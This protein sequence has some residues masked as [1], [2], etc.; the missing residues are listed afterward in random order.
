MEKDNH[1]AVA[2]SSKQNK[3][4]QH[5]HSKPMMI[6]VGL[7][8]LSIGLAIATHL[9]LPK[10]I[11]PRAATKPYYNWSDFYPFYLTEHSDPICK[12]LHLVGTSIST[13]FML[14]KP[15]SILAIVTALS[16]GYMLCEIL[17]GYSTGLI[18]FGVMGLIFVLGNWSLTGATGIEIPVVAYS[19]AWV[20][21][22]F[23]EHNNPA[24]F[25]YPSYSLMGDY[26]MT[27]D[28]LT[29]NIKLFS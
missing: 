24:S 25:I 3:N 28:I 9:R 8:A 7:C 11:T 16:I 20:G 5:D 26:R 19:M 22:F 4:K 15:K 12:V 29:N 1:K 27:F 18:E 13:L 23:Y 14:R 21:H 10:A 2:K 6:W 17:S